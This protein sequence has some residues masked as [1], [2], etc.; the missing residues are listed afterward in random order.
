MVGVLYS[1]SG[2]WSFGGFIMRFWLFFL[3]CIR[4]LRIRGIWI[5]LFKYLIIVIYM[6][7]FIFICD[8]LKGGGVNI[9]Y[10]F[11]CIIFWWF[12]CSLLMRKMGSGLDILEK[13]VLLVWILRVDYGKVMDVNRVLIFIFYGMVC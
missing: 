3:W 8:I 1:W 10:I 4:K 12:F 5:D 13:M 7:K 11:F 2:I 6:Y 9:D